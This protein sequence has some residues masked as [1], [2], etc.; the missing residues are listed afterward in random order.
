MPLR[1]L[2]LAVLLLSAACEGKTAPRDQATL[3]VDSNSRDKT[4]KPADTDTIQGYRI[5]SV[6]ARLYSS[7]STPV[8]PNLIDNAHATLFNVAQLRLRITVTVKWGRHETRPARINLWARANGKEFFAQEVPFVPT[9]DST[10]RVQD[11]WLDHGHCD[12]LLIRAY[13]LAGGPTESEMYR[14][15]PYE[16]AD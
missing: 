7:D 16:C 13:L 4:V 15:L 9:P 2:L 12:G 1:G 6:E 5:T 8:S 3:L 11:F 14:Y 10:M